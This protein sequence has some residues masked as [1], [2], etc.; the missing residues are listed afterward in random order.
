MAGAIVCW[1]LVCGAHGAPQAPGTGRVLVFTD[2]KA[3]SSQGGASQV[4]IA[5]RENGG[6]ARRYDVFTPGAPRRGDP[7]VDATGQAVFADLEP[8][9]YSVRIQA[10]GPRGEI[11]GTAHG[12][13]VV[14]SGAEAVAYLPVHPSHVGLPPA[15]P[16]RC[17]A[18]NLYQE[19]EGQDHW[20]EIDGLAPIE[21][22]GSVRG[23][24]FA[25]TDLPGDHKG[26]DRNFYLAPDADYAGLVADSNDTDTRYDGRKL[27]ECEWDS[28]FSP[29]SRTMSPPVSNWPIVGDRAWVSGP[30]IYDC[31]HAY[32][33]F[34]IPYHT[35]FHAWAASPTPMAEAFT[36]FDPAIEQASDAAPSLTYR[37]Y[38]TVR[39]GFGAQDYV[40]DVPLPPRPP[41]GVAVYRVDR[42]APLGVAIGLTPI[43]P[44]GVFSIADSMAASQPDDLEARTAHVR[45]RLQL[46]VQAGRAGYC[47]T[48][49]AGW[50]QP[51]TT[52]TYR[53]VRVTFDKLRIFR[54]HAAWLTPTAN[55]W[56][57]VQAGDQWLD[58]TDVAALHALASPQ[59]LTVDQSTAPFFVVDPSGEG[60]GLEGLWRYGLPKTYFAADVDDTGWRSGDMDDD[61]GCALCPSNLV[62]NASLGEIPLTLPDTASASIPVPQS[63]SVRFGPLV[64]SDPVGQSNPPAGVRGDL[65]L[66]G[67]LTTLAT[68]PAGMRNPT[69]LRP[70]LSSGADH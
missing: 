3:L 42:P 13:L 66:S 8:A 63:G 50:W 19:L 5:L 53:L 29:Q 24:W 2:W 47:G 64:S 1:L 6:G 27:M 39:P 49:T 7:G 56:L 28:G 67:T 14:A 31:D 18:A 34:R 16:A 17:G 52:L 38:L 45:V 40:F 15:P 69:V 58:W 68:Y 12:L 22:Y 35:E 11:A 57:W 25:D 51:Q 59:T 61:F 32:P 60:R 55:W 26:H 70:P 65:S 20:I 10:L 23:S 30:W 36:R 62:E 9:S 44:Q 54:L 37:T 21:A 43:V 46:D 48:I 4:T 41:G 33:G